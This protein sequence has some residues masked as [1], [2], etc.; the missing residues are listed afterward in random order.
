M[1]L[2]MSSCA[3]R[4]DVWSAFQKDVQGAMQVLQRRKRGA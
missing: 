1:G 3:H 4:E 2:Q